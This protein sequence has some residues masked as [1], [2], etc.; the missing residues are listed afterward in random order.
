MNMQVKSDTQIQTHID[1]Y[2]IPNGARAIIGQMMNTIMDYI[3]ANKIYK[4]SLDNV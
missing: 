2:I 4:D 1:T 3:N